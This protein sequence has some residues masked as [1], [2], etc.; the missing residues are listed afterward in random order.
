[1]RNRR[2]GRALN[3]NRFELP[4]DVALHVEK[5]DKRFILERKKWYRYIFSLFKNEPTKYFQALEGVTFEVGRGEVIGLIGLNGS[6][7]STLASLLAGHLAPTS[8]NI[9][10]N[11]VASL[12]AINS[13]MKPNLTGIENIRLKLL[14]MDFKPAE[15]KRRVRSIVEFTELHD[16]IYQPLK[17]YSSGMRAKLGFAIA[18]QTDP[19]ILIIDEAL[20]VGDQTFYQ[21]CL[22]EIERFK[23]EGKTIFFVSHAISQIREISDRVAW[24][25]YGQMKMLGNTEEVCLEYSKFIHHFNKKSKPERLREQQEMMN[26][27]KRNLTSRQKMYRKTNLWQ[28]LISFSTILLILIISAWQMFQN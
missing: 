28:Q 17:H 23:Q 10:R 7:K 20:S 26:S 15:I 18:V 21:K 27:Q 13:G 16:F 11:G 25:H 22:Q 3:K 8:G 5:V 12:L 2:S 6:G 19:D 1:M 4:N 14:L 24:I 9:R